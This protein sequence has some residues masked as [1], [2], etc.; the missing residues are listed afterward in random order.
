ML[1]DEERS[2]SK[3]G[4]ILLLASPLLNEPSLVSRLSC[5]FWGGFLRNSQVFAIIPR[6]NATSY[7]MAFRILA[8]LVFTRRHMT[9]VTKYKFF[10]QLGLRDRGIFGIDMLGMIVCLKS[11]LRL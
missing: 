10:G 11:F 6:L 8:I 9:F 2:L 1:R 5:F 4:V 7:R 3:P